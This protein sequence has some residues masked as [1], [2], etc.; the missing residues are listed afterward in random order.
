MNEESIDDETVEDDQES[1]EEKEDSP[2]PKEPTRTDYMAG[3]MLANGIIWVWMQA[4]SLFRAQ[5]SKIPTSLLAD[6]SYIIY[7]LGGY[8]AAQQV[9]NRADSQHLK[10]GVKTALYSFAMT[11]FIMLTMSSEPSF[12]LL[13]SIMLCLF[14]GGI[15]GGYMHIRKRLQ[16]RQLELEAS[17]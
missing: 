10:V 6:I 7:I 2:T 1:I 3:A 11:I 17:S 13:T 8:F 14:A 15:L 4:L 5:A 9:S 12:T 16:R